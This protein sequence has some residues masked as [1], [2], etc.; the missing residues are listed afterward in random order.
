MRVLFDECVPRPFRKHLPDF[1]VTTV[2]EK[3]WNGIENGELL[4][5]AAEEFDV[6][7]TV[8]KN[9]SYQQS[10]ADKNIALVLAN[11]LTNTVEE[12]LTIQADISEAIRLAQP[13]SFTEVSPKP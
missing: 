3:G 9:M 6:L 7:F 11:C 10:L 4:A 13:G 12:L 1:D 8:D 5:L 2:S